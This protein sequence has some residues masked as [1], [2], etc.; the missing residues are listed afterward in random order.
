MVNVLPK[1]GG[2]AIS[3]SGFVL[4]VMK[5]NAAGEWQLFR[6]ANLLQH[7]TGS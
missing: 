4:S 5:K 1:N 2:T 7:E 6:D 3:R